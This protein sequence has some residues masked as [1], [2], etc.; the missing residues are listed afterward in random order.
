MSSRY[1]LIIANNE[2]SDSNLAQLS[3]PGKDAEDLARVLQDKN[4]AGFDD[5]KVILNHP[6]SYVRE[7]IDEFFDLKKPD[8]LLLLYFSGHGVRDEMG[9]L[10]LALKNT[11]RARLR[12]TALRSDFIR[13]AMDQSRSKRIVLILDCCNSGA[14]AQGTKAVTGGS[15]G[16]A[17][18]FEGTGYGRIVL[19]ASDSTQ[20][21]W[22]GDKI[23]GETQN[24]LFTHFLVKGLEGDAD[25][26][27]DGRI[28]VDELYDYTYEQIVA[29]TPKQTPGKWSYKQQGEILL[30]QTT[31]IEKIRPISL[32]DELIQ[33]IEDPR[34]FVRE[35]AIHQLEKV[36][37]GKN[38]G[39]ARSA[40]EALEGIATGD[41]S[42]HVAQI[43]V[44]ILES[45]HQA[46]QV[47]IQKTETEKR[48][49]DEQS[50]IEAKR[51]AEK[52]AEDERIAREKV[53]AER[54]AEKKAED[55]RIAR[56]KA[57]AERIA[58]KKAEDERIAREKAEAKRIAEKKAEDERVAREKIETAHKIKEKE[59]RLPQ[60]FVY[61]S[62]ED[63]VPLYPSL[64]SY[65]WTVWLEKG[66]IVSI[67]NEPIEEALARIWK[68]GHYLEVADSNGNKGFVLA[69]ALSINPPPLDGDFE[70]E[71]D[72]D[73]ESSS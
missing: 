64:P 13:E 62:L 9:S 65:G 25:R 28:T 5:V 1:A 29:C 8:D 23:I 2:Y 15:I 53:E 10:Y 43:A 68:H 16:T 70:E 38:L 52:K 56:E 30:C 12:A 72:D 42:R 36:I 58:E 59:N 46:D 55:E 40:R 47:L 3:A 71:D 51:I 31:Q 39:L 34:P 35:A 73:D 54:I 26:D 6:E 33:A 48:L 17:S 32:S 50:K 69:T 14:F 22:E 21:A 67:I 27:G 61:V 37:K 7:A 18:A 66:S 4:I 63:G 19:T 44:Q 41:D 20:F 49:K 24:S 57:E 11:S 60:N 45:L